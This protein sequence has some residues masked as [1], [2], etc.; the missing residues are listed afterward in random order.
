[1]R[2]RECN[3][4]VADN[5]SRCP[6]CGAEVFDDAPALPELGDIPYPSS[7]QPYPEE[8]RVTKHDVKTYEIEPWVMER[9]K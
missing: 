6:L 7:Y 3:I 9:I 2:C 1:M 4:D 8:K 5:I